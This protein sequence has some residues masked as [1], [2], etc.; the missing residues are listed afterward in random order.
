M[1]LLVLLSCADVPTPAVFDATPRVEVIEVRAVPSVRE[2]TVLSTL[3]PVQDALLGTLRPG[4]VARRLAEPGDAVGLD[5]G[6][7]QLD[8]REARATVAAAHAAL[9][10]A[11]AVLGETGRMAGRVTALGEG[12]SK[13]QVD[14]AS[15]GAAR[16]EAGRDAAAA[17][18]QLA[19]LNLDF[20]TLRA[21]F[22]GELAWLDPDPGEAIAAGMPV[23][24]VV[25]LSSGKVVV[26]LLEDEVAAAQVEGATFVVRASAREVPASLVHV[27]PAADPRTLDWK[28]ELRVEGMPFPAGTPVEVRLGLP[29]SDAEG[30]VPPRSVRDGVV[31]RVEGTVVRRTPV[32]VVGEVREGLLVRGL[33]VG[34]QVVVHAADPLVDGAEVRLL[35]APPRAEGT[36]PGGSAP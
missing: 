31:W 23:A 11:E 4:R 32:E 5:A 33:A 19:Q 25:D 22:A 1:L 27:S 28:A 26:G 30:V 13:A 29:I 17:Q 16:A 10:E 14:A 35:S 36:V 18:L 34:A 7:L 9:A 6:L 15:T 12:V 20:M 24:R 8:D 2:R 3:E 21:P